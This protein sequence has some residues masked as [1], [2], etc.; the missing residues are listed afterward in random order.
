MPRPNECNFAIGAKGIGRFRV[1][2]FVQRGSAGMVLR[3]IENRIPGIDELLLPPVLK[4]LAM[5][6][7]GLV[8]IVGATGTGKS[9]SLA[10]LV[11]YRNR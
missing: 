2:A 11:G 10:A 7:R 4:D 3:R 9:A 8:I 6:R 5:A 1:S